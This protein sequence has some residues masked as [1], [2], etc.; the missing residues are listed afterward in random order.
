MPA[1]NRKANLLSQEKL[2]QER[3]TFTLGCTESTKGKVEARNSRNPRKE[4]IL[5]CVVALSQKETSRTT[6]WRMKRRV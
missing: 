2:P 3:K 4:G 1:F 6:C 5:A